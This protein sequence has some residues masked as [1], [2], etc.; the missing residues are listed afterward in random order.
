MKPEHAKPPIGLVAL[1]GTN[2]AQVVTN[3]TASAGFCHMVSERDFDMF[4]RTPA[5]GL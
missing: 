1:H 4:K 3:R 5:G 2:L